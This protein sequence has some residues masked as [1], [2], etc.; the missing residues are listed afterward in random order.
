MKQDFKIGDII[1][2][3]SE[4]YILKN[5]TPFGDKGHR[6][7]IDNTKDELVF[8]VKMFKYCSKK[9]VITEKMA[10]CDSGNGV[11][12]DDYYY[13]LNIAG[14]NHYFSKTMFTPINKETAKIIK[15]FDKDSLIYSKDLL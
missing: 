6:Y 14:S 13:Y 2:V 11:R 15:Q 1:R 7:L 9:A 8:N 3:Q 4:E 10:L 5:S 12:I